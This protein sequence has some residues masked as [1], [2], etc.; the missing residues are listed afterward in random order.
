MADYSDHTIRPLLSPD[1]ALTDDPIAI[2]QPDGKQLTVMRRY[3]DQRGTEGTQVYNVDSQTGE[4][5]PLVVDPTYTQG[6][7]SWSPD[8]GQLLMQRYPMVASGG[9]ST[10]T[11]SLW[12]YDVASK[13]LSK[14][15]INGF[16]PQ[17]LP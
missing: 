1:G 9:D 15:A 11:T 14:L 4:A 17:W 3:F 7:L 6:G 10:G 8:G 12:R 5:T 2:W 13:T 16:L